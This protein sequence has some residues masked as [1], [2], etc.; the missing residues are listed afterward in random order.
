LI[1]LL[2]NRAVVFILQR[3]A[4]YLKRTNKSVP[5]GARLSAPVRTGPGTHP[6]YR[7]MGTESRCRG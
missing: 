4:K 5:V 6:P 3:N 2:D 1:T 7:K